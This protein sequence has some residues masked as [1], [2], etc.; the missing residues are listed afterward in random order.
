MMDFCGANG[1]DG[2]R[3]RWGTFGLQFQSKRFISELVTGCYM[4][5][6]P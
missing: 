1:L 5:K 6:M 2:F 3:I 4:P